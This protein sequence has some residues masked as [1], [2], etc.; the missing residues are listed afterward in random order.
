MQRD[1]GI[2]R[3]SLTD[4]VFE[5][6]KEKILDRVLPP[7]ERLTIDALARELQVSSSPLR[8]ALVRLHG[9][10]LVTQDL[11]R[12]YRV[13]A[14]PSPSYLAELADFRLFVEG[15]AAETGAPRCGPETLA[16]MRAAY[17]R[18][19]A[20]DEI[21]T[22][23]RQYRDFFDA[24]AAFHEL[25]VAS[26]GN[27]PLLDAYCALRSP[28]IL[29]RIYRERGD[30]HRRALETRRQHRANL[31]AYEAG[32]GEAARAAVEAHLEGGRRRLLAASVQAASVQVGP[33]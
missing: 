22:R 25:I 21:G 17:R 15:H 30:G 16:A 20:G 33:A 19:G 27:R 18:M 31:R 11:F 26:A 6:L 29:A 24:D 32:D 3:T 7:G 2:E 1:G 12:G 5:I 23:Y 8:E 28:L 14:A 13:A 9:E 4:Q 10:G